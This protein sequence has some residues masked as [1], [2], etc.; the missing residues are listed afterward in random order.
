MSRQVIPCLL[1]SCLLVTLHYTRRFFGGRQPLCGIGVTSVIERTRSPLACRARMA[2]SR[3]GPGPF[4]NTSTSITPMSDAVL[5]AFWPARRAAYGV[6]LRLPLNPACPALPQA[7][8]L[9]LASVMVT[10]V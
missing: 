5:A 8:A 2:A 6:D 4:T 10:I 1:V 3:P 9:P 7:T